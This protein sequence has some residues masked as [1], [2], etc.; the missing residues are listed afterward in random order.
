MDDEVMSD[1]N[2]EGRTCTG[3]SNTEN[4][5]TYGPIWNIYRTLKTCKD[6]RC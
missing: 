4:S 2:P 1:H 3:S 5:T 6:A